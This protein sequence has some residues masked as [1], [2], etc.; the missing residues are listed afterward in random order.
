MA[1]DVGSI[2]PF[3]PLQMPLS[4]MSFSGRGIPEWGIAG[5]IGEDNVFL[6]SYAMIQVPFF[7]LVNLFKRKFRSYVS[8]I[9][10]SFFSAF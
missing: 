2:K 5:T 6:T 7:N 4:Q 10:D 9:W 3:K 1:K 8:F